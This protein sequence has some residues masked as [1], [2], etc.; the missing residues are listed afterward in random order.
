MI[1][2]GGIRLAICVSCFIIYVFSMGSF[3]NQQIRETLLKKA[4][5]DYKKFSASLIP[6]VNN[7]LGIR[8]PFLRD[9]AKALVCGDWR[10][11]LEEAECD[12]FEEVMLQGMV[13]GFASRK[14][15]ERT[16]ASAAEPDLNETLLMVEQFV[17]KISNWSLCDS[18]CAGLK[19]VKRN[20]AVVW[21]FLQKYLVSDKEFELRFGVVLLLDYYID[22]DYIDRILDVLGNVRH[23][24]RYVK[25]AVAWALS[26][27]VVKQ[28]EKT[29]T[30]LQERRIDKETLQMTK[31][32]VYDSFRVSEADKAFVRGLA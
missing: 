1:W 32:K 11:Y 12:Y 21:N 2:L 5:S 15:T 3:I 28:R 27:C 6:G 7:M 18:F 17:P 8:L 16:C 20:K 26:V 24:S 29:L 31:Q 9:M 14:T 10:A 22:S 13:V 19:F 25:M 30:F 23:D 4:E